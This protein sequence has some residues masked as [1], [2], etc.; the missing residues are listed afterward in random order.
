MRLKFQKLI[1]ICLSLS[2][3]YSVARLLVLSLLASK[4]LDPR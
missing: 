2:R 3:S 1:K 4:L